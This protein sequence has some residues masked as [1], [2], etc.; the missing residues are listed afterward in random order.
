MCCPSKRIY[1]ISEADAFN[2]QEV[3]NAYQ[4]KRIIFQ[5]NSLTSIYGVYVIKRNE[6]YCVDTYT[7]VFYVYCSIERFFLRIY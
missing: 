3:K 1:G 7:Y 2:L 4:G 5:H 6:G